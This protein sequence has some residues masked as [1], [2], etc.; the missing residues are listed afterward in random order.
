MLFKS[1]LYYFQ[2]TRLFKPFLFLVQCVSHFFHLV[3]FHINYMQA[4]FVFFHTV[5]LFFSFVTLLQWNICQPFCV[6]SHLWSMIHFKTFANHCH[7]C[8]LKKNHASVMLITLLFL[9]CRFICH[10]FFPRSPFLAVYMPKST[11][12]LEALSPASTLH[13]I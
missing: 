6:L 5:C 12:I 7:N 9:L 2:T 11:H 8:N 1:F 13:Q 10:Q 3:H 4:G